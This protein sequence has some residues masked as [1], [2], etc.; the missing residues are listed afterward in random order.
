MV[1]GKNLGQYGSKEPRNTLCK[2]GSKE[3][4]KKQENK[5]NEQSKNVRTKREKKLRKAEFNE[6]SEELVKKICKSRRKQ[7]CKNVCP[8]GNN[9]NGMKVR[10]KT[11]KKL[12]NKLGRKISKEISKK[13]CKNCSKE[14]GKKAFQKGESSKKP[15]IKYAKIVD[16]S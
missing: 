14:V 5:S 4:G 13:V 11:R 10:V 16:R 2:K 8:K 7:Q 3:I 1:L 12:G 9:P 6:G 15:C